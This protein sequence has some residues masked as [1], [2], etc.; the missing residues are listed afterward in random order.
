MNSE[1]S[2]GGSFA[3]DLI[4][5]R[6]NA[7]DTLTRSL[8][9]QLLERVEKVEQGQDEIKGRLQQLERKD[10]FRQ[11]QMLVQTTA[12]QGAFRVGLVIL[13]AF[14]AGF[15]GSLF[16]NNIAAIPPTHKQDTSIQT[17]LKEE[18]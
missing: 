8:N 7:S 12:R 17:P 6:I 16:E 13:A 5:D 10:E 11:G 3:V 18:S 1:T 2:V 14:A 4:L 9:E 15:A